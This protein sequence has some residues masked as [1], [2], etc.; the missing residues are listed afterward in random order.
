MLAALTVMVSAP[1]LAKGG[2]VRRSEPVPLEATTGSIPHSLS[3]ENFGGCGHGRYRE[4]GTH[5]C[6]GPAD[7]GG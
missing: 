1:A 6:R 7:F 2:Y 5:K 4:P 3:I